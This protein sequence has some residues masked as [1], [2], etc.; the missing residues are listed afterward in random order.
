[1]EGFLH[2]GEFFVFLDVIG[3]AGETPLKCDQ[4][5][6]QQPRFHKSVQIKQTGCSDSCRMSGIVR[7]LWWLL[8]SHAVCN[9][10]REQLDFVLCQGSQLP[11]RLSFRNITSLAWTTVTEYLYFSKTLNYFYYCCVSSCLFFHF[12]L[13]FTM[14]VSVVMREN[15]DCMIRWFVQVTTL[16]QCSHSLSSSR[17]LHVDQA[18]VCVH[19]NCSEQ[20]YNIKLL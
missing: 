17:L 2:K 11:H 14:R 12:S 19:T 3:S 20:R 10:W 13:Q 9:T 16:T 1:M 18:V 8:C 4:W 6:S 7:F 15:T 5:R